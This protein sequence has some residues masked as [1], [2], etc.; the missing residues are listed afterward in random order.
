MGTISQSL[1]KQMQSSIATLSKS[2]TEAISID[3]ETFISAFQFKMNEDELAELFQSLITKENV[4]YESNL[5]KLN[6][7]NISDGSF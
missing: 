6:Y 7:A 1:Q 5:K 2:I 4:T 3:E